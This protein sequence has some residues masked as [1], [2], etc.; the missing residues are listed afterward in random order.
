MML[1]TTRLPQNLTCGMVGPELGVGEARAGDEVGLVV[2]DRLDELGD[3]GGVELPVAVDVDDDVGAAAHGA[4]E[5]GAE[6][7][8]QPRAVVQR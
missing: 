2:E 5:A 3:V 8:A 1:V 7:L 4:L 6:D